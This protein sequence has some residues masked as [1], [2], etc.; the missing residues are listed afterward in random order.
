V[1][2]SWIYAEKRR[3]G[4][5]WVRTR[6][7]A[8]RAERAERAINTASL[9]NG[10]IKS[11][12]ATRCAEEERATT[13]FVGERRSKRVPRCDPIKKAAFSSLR[14]CSGVQQY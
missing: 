5:E 4:E 13:L 2:N 11:D 7:R 1:P 3:I 8:I 12:R 6:G 9:A 14:R 10:A